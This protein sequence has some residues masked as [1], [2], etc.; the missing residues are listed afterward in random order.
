MTTNTNTE[1]KDNNGSPKSIAFVPDNA[2]TTVLGNKLL[3]DVTDGVVSLTA[4]AGASV[5]TTDSYTLTTSYGKYVLKVTA[6]GT[7]T[8]AKYS[9]TLQA[10]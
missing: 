1:L 8:T 3:L 9:L 2:T 5:T 4:T 10:K 7:T 6:N